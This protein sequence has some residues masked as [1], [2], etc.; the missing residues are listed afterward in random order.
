MFMVRQEFFQNFGLLRTY[1]YTLN[2]LTT[3][4]CV[5]LYQPSRNPLI[6]KT[7]LG[8]HRLEYMDGFKLFWTGRT[9]SLQNSKET[10]YTS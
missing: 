6:T 4:V 8:S 2:L 3:N 1:C 10:D 7:A 5:P 9:Q